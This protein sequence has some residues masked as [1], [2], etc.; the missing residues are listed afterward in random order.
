MK[1]ILSKVITFASTPQIFFLLV[2]FLLIQLWFSK[3]LLFGGTEVGIP[4]YTPG[5]TLGQII[6]LWWEALGPGASFPTTVA[7]I[8]LYFFMSLLEKIG[9]GAIEIQKIL[10]FIIIYL[11]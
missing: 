7:S 6:W 5:K 8:P 1:K 2:A 10:F 9:L 11:Q 4:T 3:S